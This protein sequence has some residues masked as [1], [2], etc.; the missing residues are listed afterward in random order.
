MANS[1]GTLRNALDDSTS[2]ARNLGQLQRPRRVRG[3]FSSSLDTLDFIDFYKFTLLGRSSVAISTKGLQGN[4]NLRL[5]DGQSKGIA[6]SNK[7]GKKRDVVRQ[8]LE[9]GTYYIQVRN[10]STNDNHYILRASSVGLP[11]LPGT[12]SGTGGG[13]NT[14]NPTTTPV[15]GPAPSPLADDNNSL[16]AKAV[17]LGN[18]AGSTTLKDRV[19]GADAADFYSFSLSQAS[20]VTLSAS[21]IT[22]GTVQVSLVYDINGNGFADRGDEIASSNGAE[23]KKALG[24]GTYFVGVTA[25]T[26]SNVGYGVKLQTAAIPDIS[27]TSDPPMGL[28]GATLLT[29][30]SDGSLGGSLSVK[31]IVSPSDTTNGK[32]L[33]TFDSTDIYKF[34]LKDVSN[35]SAL[36]D[37]S[38]STGNVT[39]SLIYDEDKNGIANPGE[40]IDGLVQGGDFIGG[41]FTGGSEGGAALGVNKTLGAGTYYVAVTQRKVTEGTTYKLNLFVNSTVQGITPTTD[42][43]LGMSTAFNV[44][45]LNKNVTYKQFVGSVDSSDFYKFTI[46]KERNIIIRYNGSPELVALRFGQDLNGNGVFGLGEDSITP[47]GKLDTGEDTNNNGVLDREVFGQQLSGNVIYNPLPPFHNSTDA[48][49]EYRPEVNGFLTT[50]PTDIYARLKPGTY[51]IQ[52]DPQKTT[53][54]LGDGLDRYGSANVLYNLSFLLD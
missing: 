7:P 11:P 12:D 30:Q 17:A 31:Q 20:L 21:D 46:D 3:A 32:L 51:Y 10:A 52:V 53:A 33:G 2:G 4:V 54:D 16:P 50:V 24:A 9:A 22:D 18:L 47:N 26:G 29:N 25:A 13:T 28:G 49:F 40:L 41:V 34:T 45:T 23:I 43:G 27:P 36:L 39:M 44:G 6:S 1:G 38:Q 37:S 19:G 14:N 48:K 8:D 5:L 42:P 15:N 35:F